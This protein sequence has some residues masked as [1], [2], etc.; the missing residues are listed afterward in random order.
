MALFLKYYERA[1]DSL[2]VGLF[3]PSALQWQGSRGGARGPALPLFLDPKGGP[4]GRK[5]L[6]GGTVP[7]LISGSGSVTALTPFYLFPLCTYLR[8]CY[9]QLDK[10]RGLFCTAELHA[11]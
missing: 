1:E 6:G 7:P 11:K 9:N 8:L 5:N 4:K 10:I 3:F 2:C